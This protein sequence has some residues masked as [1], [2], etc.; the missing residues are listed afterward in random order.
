MLTHELLRD[1]GILILRPQ[2]P[3]QAGDFTSLA[4]VVDPYLEEHGTLRGIMVDAPSFPGWDSFAALASH[5]RFVRD[6]HRLI[7]KVAAV[8]D[9]PVLSLGPKLAKHFVKA[10]I[11]NFKGNER[12][13]ALAWLRQ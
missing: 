1:E 9:S 8:S 10:E 7:G 12:A 13:A 6:H 2:G 3:L 5:L 11:R 4:T